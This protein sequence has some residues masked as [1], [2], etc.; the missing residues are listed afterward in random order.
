MHTFPL[1]SRR[2]LA[3]AL[4]AVGAGIGVTAPAGAEP[5]DYRQLPVDPNL[6]TDSTA[7]IAMPPVLD[8]DG[9]TGVEQVFTHRDDSRHITDTVLVL[10]DPQSAGTALQGLQANLGAD[11]VGQETQSVTLGDNGIVVSGTSPD[12]S[13]AV[14]VLLFTRGATAT[15]IQFAGPPSDPVPLDLVTEYGQ[16]QDD[17]I[18]E[19]LNQ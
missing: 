1:S 12:G 10:P 16:R 15:E 13:Q 11:V 4:M 19:Q 3:V 5:V 17:A 8:P 18:R 9:Q 6:I 2:L 14:A 7:Y